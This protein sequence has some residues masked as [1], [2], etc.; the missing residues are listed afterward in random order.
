MT[1]LYGNAARPPED[2]TTRARIIDA[3]LEQFASRGIAGTTMRSIAEAAGVS[4]GLVQHHFGTKDGIRAACDERML[5]LVRL[6]VANTMPDGQITN[7]E[8]LGTLYDAASPVMPYVA[9]VALETDDRAAAL[10]D[11]IASLSAQFLSTWWSE[12][13]PP[14]APRT[15]DAAAALLAMNMST[16]VLHHQLARQMGL[17]DD[18]P[19]PSSRVGIAAL[20]VYQAM[21]ELLSSPFGVKF[22]DAVDAYYREA[23]HHHSPQPDTPEGPER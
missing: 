14:N 4:V 2:L 20:D 13:F 11:E 16:I 21:G 23:D 22:R 19:L 18:E 12:R 3:A 6:K 9:R 15:R 7:P 1:S 17:A 5:A 10:F 8:F